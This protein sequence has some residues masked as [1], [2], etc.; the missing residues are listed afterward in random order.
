MDMSVVRTNAPPV[1]KYQSAAPRTLH[2]KTALKM[3]LPTGINSPPALGSARKS[4]RPAGMQNTE[5]RP[6]KRPEIVPPLQIQ[7][8]ANR[9]L[10]SSEDATIRRGKFSPG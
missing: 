1:R 7:N 8:L 2:N 4:V 9:D 5:T 3:R 6:P 10:D